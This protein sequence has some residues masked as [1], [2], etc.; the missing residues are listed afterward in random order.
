MFFLQ[1]NAPCHGKGSEESLAITFLKKHKIK[2]LKHPPNSPDLSLVELVWRDIKQLPELAL[3]RTKEDL[4]AAYTKA[5]DKY[6][7]PVMKKYCKK[8]PELMAKLIETKGYACM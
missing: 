8:M 3:C 6:K 2:Y 1:D 5:W 7:L 4:A